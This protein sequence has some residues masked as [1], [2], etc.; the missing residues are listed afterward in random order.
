MAPQVGR[1]HTL[2]VETNPGPLAQPVRQ[3]GQVAVTIQIVRVQS[4]RGEKDKLNARKQKIVTSKIEGKKSL[5]N[6]L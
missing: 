4:T 2:S 1:A 3:P 5:N 6:D